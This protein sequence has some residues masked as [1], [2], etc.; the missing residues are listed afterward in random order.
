VAAALDELI[1]AHQP[2]HGDFTDT[3]AVAQALKAIFVAAGAS[4]FGALQREA[5]DMIAV[6]LARICAGDPTC[7]DHWRDLAGYA[8]LAGRDLAG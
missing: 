1:D 5:L 2:T 3:A 4:R 8:R 6:K 7:E